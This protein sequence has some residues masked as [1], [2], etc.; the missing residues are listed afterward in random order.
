VI[1]PDNDIDARIAEA[2]K[3][4]ET[5]RAKRT[6]EHR[7]SP[8][9][10]G[11]LGHYVEDPYTAVKPRPAVHDQVDVVLVGAG[12]AGLLAAAELR[13]SGVPK[14]RLIDT[15]GD[16]GGVWYWNRYPECKCDV[17]SLIYLPLLEETGYIPSTRYAPAPE[18]GEH[19][20]RIARHFDLYEH[21]LFHTGVKELA[22]DD[23]LNLWHVRTDRGDDFLARFVSLCLGPLSKVKLP[24][25][26]GVETF[27]GH[28]FHTSRWDY[29][30]TGGGPTDPKLNKLADKSV[31]FIGTGATGLQC[32]APLAESSR[33]FY[34]F[35][36]TPSTV[37][38][39]D[40][41]PIEPDLVKNFAPGWQRRRMENFTAVNF[42]KPVKEDLIKD[43]WTRLFGD[44]VSS[45]RFKGLQGEALARERERVDFEKMEEIRR[46][47]DAIVTDPETAEK[48]KPYYRYMCKRPGW[49]DEYLAA[50]NL[51]NCTLVDTDG[52]GVERIT[53]SGIVVAGKEYKLDC[54]IYGTGF[55]TE[56]LGKLRTGIDIFGRNGQPLTEHWGKGL[57]T[58]HGL[59]VSGFP[60]LFIVPGL[61]GQAVVTTNV[62]H[63]TSEIAEHIGY[64]V[65]IILEHS[66]DSFELTPEAEEGWVQTI[67]ARRVD[68]TEFYK[69]CTPGRYNYEGD[70][71]ARPLQNTTFGGGPFEY[72]G[73]LAEWRESGNLPG[74][75]LLKDGAA[76]ILPEHPYRHVKKEE[77]DAGQFSSMV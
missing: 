18:I 46:R 17:E 66:L 49:H 24:D 21:A 26:P 25:I 59:L 9:L 29:N 74:L 52:R 16:V 4:Y 67:L 65:R 64:I 11:D 14:I 42:G 48:L 62:I 7:G 23:E 60:N 5:E 50:F 56:T 41:G 39:R 22:W 20:R 70:V 27:K 36:R 33:Q 43:G 13:K 6:Q 38:P 71:N 15:A 47:I 73:L 19:A 58:L 54:L 28:A 53:E 68:N 76:V 61:Q 75:T 55:E 3:K 69:A 2:R 10:V 35:Q 40:N 51:P 45:P 8:E 77:T 72:F 31:G 37:G 34:L 12:F 30:Y 32:V 1:Q 57:R 44:L 63:L